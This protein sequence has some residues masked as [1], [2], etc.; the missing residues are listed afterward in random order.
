MTNRDVY[1]AAL[2]LLAEAQ[3]ELS[4]DYA[5]RAPY[6]FSTFFGECRTLD[7]MHK[8]ALRQSEVELYDTSPHPDLDDEFP[9]ADCFYTPGVFYVAAMLVELEN[10]ELSDRFFSR[11]ADAISRIAHFGV[12]A[13][14]H[15]TLDV[16][17][18]HRCD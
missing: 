14:S 15:T 12:P 9:L 6:V 7:G 2:A 18:F 11:Y 5:Q 3:D 10:P 8:S 16:Y 13:R 17:G 1:D 4:D